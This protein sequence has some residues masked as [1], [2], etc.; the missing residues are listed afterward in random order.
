MNAAG[1]W[2][3]AVRHD[4]TA[5]SFALEVQGRRAHLAYRSEAGTMT[6]T[7][8]FVPPELRGRGLAEVL[9]RAA[10]DQARVERCRVV[11]ECTYAAR[12][13]ERHPDFGDLAAR[14]P[15]QKARVA[16]ALPPPPS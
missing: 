5:G 3:G 2:T 16:A 14:P 12:F 7:H 1:D 10:L 4:P 15:S 11:P 9:V 8:T 6:I 13:L